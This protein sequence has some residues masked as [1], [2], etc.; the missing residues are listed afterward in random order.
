M[1]R[2]AIRQATCTE[3]G[4]NDDN[5]TVTDTDMS[6]DDD[7]LTYDT[8]CTCGVEGEVTLDDEGT[9]AGENISHEDASWNEESDDDE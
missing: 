5:H 3:C 8:R 7:T 6:I 2:Q 4:E 1:P 9:N